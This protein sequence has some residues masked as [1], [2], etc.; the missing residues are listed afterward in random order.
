MPLILCEFI[1][2][3]VLVNLLLKWEVSGVI[4]YETLFYTLKNDRPT[5]HW[6]HMFSKSIY[7]K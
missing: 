4:S 3:L 6:N 2:M 1:A 7:R 5:V